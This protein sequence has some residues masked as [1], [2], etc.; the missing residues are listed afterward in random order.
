[1]KFEKLDPEEILADLPAFL[2]EQDYIF[3]T[4][5]FKQNYPEL[6]VSEIKEWIA[7]ADHDYHIVRTA[8]LVMGVNDHF[9]FIIEKMLGASFEPP[10][11][12]L[13]SKIDSVEFVVVG[14]AIGEV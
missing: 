6:S 10:A 4:D 1:M 7:E 2:N 5:Y 14:E 13:A 12:F 11:V 9:F 8:Y 3:E